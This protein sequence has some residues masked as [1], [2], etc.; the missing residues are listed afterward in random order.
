MIEKDDFIKFNNE[1]AFEQ[2]LDIEEKT[3]IKVTDEQA[4]KIIEKY[5]NASEFQALDIRMRDRCLKKL[6]ESGLS[7][8]QISR[9]TGVSY[10]LIQKM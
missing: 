2:C 7:I 4:R 5:K 10:Y 3:I 8:R 9:L 1:K 6:R